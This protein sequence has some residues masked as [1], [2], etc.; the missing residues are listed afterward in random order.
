MK[1]LCINLLF[2]LFPR[3][4]LRIIS[5]RVVITLL[6]L[7]FFLSG[8]CFFLFFYLFHFSC[9]LESV[10]LF[11]ILGNTLTLTMHVLSIFGDKEFL[12]EWESSHCWWCQFN[13]QLRE[14]YLF[15]RSSI[16]YLPNF[17]TG[18]CRELFEHYE[19]NVPLIVL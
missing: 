18:S 5:D 11:F 15:V 7:S 17:V 6:L 12:Y 3:L 9:F 4:F 1:I 19:G 2:F 8:L 16:I 10:V 13:L 14:W